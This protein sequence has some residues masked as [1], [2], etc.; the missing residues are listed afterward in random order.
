[1]RPAVESST[2]T[3]YSSRLAHI[4]IMVLPLAVEVILH[5]RELLDDG[6]D[7]VTEAGAGQ[8]LID[9]LHFG[10]LASW[11]MRLPATSISDCRKAIAS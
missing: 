9:H 1:L 10:L 2:P 11:A 7:A 6:V 5:V 3:S 8:V 4:R